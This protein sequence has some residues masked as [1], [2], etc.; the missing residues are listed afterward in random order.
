MHA[1]RVLRASAAL[2]LVLAL[3]ARCDPYPAGTAVRGESPPAVRDTAAGPKVRAALTRPDYRWVTLDTRNLRLRA[4]EGSYA[5][6]HLAEL[7]RQAEAARAH[8]LAL[9][10]AREYPRLQHFFVA[11]RPEMRDLVGM[12]YGGDAEPSEN[13]VFLVATPDIPPALR[14]ETMHVLA[15]QLW[16]RPREQWISEG[17]AIHAG[18]QCAG[19]S[20]HE[21]AAAL[22]AEG[23]RVPLRTLV[24]SFPRVNDVVS[25]LQ[26]GSLVSYVAGRWGMGAVHTLWTGGLAAA[27]RATGMTAPQL[28]SAWTAELARPAYH[29]RR[30][31]WELIRAHGCEWTP[32]PG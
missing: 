11:S 12:P 25:Y 26:G 10:G 22:G 16:G 2:P 19:R 27:P 24:D 32:P 8:G 9:L 14:H 31:D 20:L 17:L 28:E 13:A 1:R 21:W 29:Q 6:A 23:R 4:R 3:G 7:G 15:I 18:G 5:A 30:A